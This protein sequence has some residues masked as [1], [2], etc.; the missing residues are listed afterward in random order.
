MTMRSMA[1]P[2]GRA[3]RPDQWRSS[4]D[5]SGWVRTV[6][7]VAYRVAAQAGTPSAVT[8]TSGPAARRRSLSAWMSRVAGSRMKRSSVMVIPFVVG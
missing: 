6:M 4:L 3:S 8:G 5:R 7:S 2:G 1:V